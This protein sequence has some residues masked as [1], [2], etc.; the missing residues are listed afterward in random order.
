MVH[1]QQH[2]GEMGIGHEAILDVFPMKVN[3]EE[4]GNGILIE[5]SNFIDA[6]VDHH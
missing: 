4:V 1:L 6:V 5:C 3:L 2:K